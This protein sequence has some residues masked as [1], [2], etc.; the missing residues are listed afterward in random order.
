MNTECEIKIN[1]NK[2]TAKPGQTVLEACRENGVFVPSLCNDPRLNPFG[3]CMICRVE[4]EKQR[5][6]PLACYTTVAEGM[7][8][9]TESDTIKMIRKMCLEFLASQHYGDCTAPCVLEC[10]A[11]TNVQGYIHHITNGEYD[12]ALKL[13]KETNPLP[14]VCGRICT[15]PCEKKCRRN[16]FEGKI[17]IAYL[18]RFVADIDKKKDKPYLPEKKSATG[19]KAAIIGAGPAGLSAAWFLA[20]EGHGVTIYER[21]EKPGG[22]LRYG[23][24]SYRMPRET[25]DEEIDIIKSLGIE[26]NYNVEFGKDVTVESLKAAGFGAILLAVGSQKGYPLG[27]DGEKDCPNVLIGVDFLGSVTR[28]KQPDFTGK[29]IAVVGGGNTAMDCART[30]VRLGAQSVKIIYRRTLAEIPADKEEIEQS[31]LEGVEY[32]F[33]T[34]PLSVSQNGAVIA[35]KLTKMELGEPDASGRRAPRPIAGSEYTIEADYVISAI[36]QTQDLS[37]IGNDCN[38][39]ANRGRLM[40]DQYTAMTSI[41][42]IFAAGDGVTGPQTAIMAIAGGKRAA[43]AMDKYMKGE[44]V[45]TIKENYNHVKAK[46]YREIDP[47]T[48]GDVEKIEKNQMP[49]LT[50]E[51]RRHNFKEVELGL[52]EEQAKREAA[53]CLACG[54]GDADNCKLRQ[55]A[56]TYD[57]DQFAFISVIK[58]HPIDKSH[59]YIIRDQNKCI[60][61]GRCVRICLE[62]GCGVL[63][64]VGRGFNAQVDPAF[65]DPLGEDKNCIDCGLCVSTCPTG[66]LQPREGVVLPTTAY[67]DRED[68]VLTGISDAVEQAKKVTA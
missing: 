68:F 66:A 46:D 38:V 25:L 21:Q 11:H 20:Q 41:E 27:V 45:F 50:K 9:T 16:I 51:E 58:T 44:S 54:C 29:R 10:P 56:T 42:G 65:N 2:C 14:V 3:S 60:L 12:E 34:N 35:M 43:L 30:S 40:A 49:V 37:F 64:F 7:V 63:E 57:A 24:P 13:I 31:Q 28:G 19:K 62:T 47:A 8:I 6:V 23:I 15:R 26:I 67:S 52:S 17:G 36:G 18:K 4:I 5:G 48:Y 55:Y 61:C 33:L 59:K 1:G 39:S 53:R 32:S 22:M